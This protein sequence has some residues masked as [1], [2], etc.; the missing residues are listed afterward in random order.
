MRLKSTLT[1]LISCAALATA[2][3]QTIQCCDTLITTD[4][5]VILFKLV[6]ASK[7]RLR[8]V[9]CGDPTRKHRYLPTKSAK[10]IT[11]CETQ[12]YRKD[13]P[14]NRWGYLSPEPVSKYLTF[15]V[16]TSVGIGNTSF[17]SYN[18]RLPPRIGVEWGLA[19]GTIR[20]GLMYQFLLVS[21][22]FRKKG[23]NGELGL[24]LKKLIQGKLSGNPSNTY[25]G[26]DVRAGREKVIWRYSPSV[27]DTY[28]WVDV[29]A[30]LGL[31]IPSKIFVFDFSL[32]LGASFLYTDILSAHLTIRPTI[33]LGV[34]F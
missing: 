26:F 27:L 21:S 20:A 2:C 25:F 11:Y 31:H 23:V 15:Y 16:G 22:D 9:E 10:S 1:A 34:R 28:Q 5:R 8:Y 29:M 18:R 30:T 6:E 19:D 32:P 12:P 3:S 33:S 13:T 7:E 17:L 24:T 4:D 14:P